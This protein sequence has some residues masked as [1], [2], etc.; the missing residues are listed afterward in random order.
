MAL[1]LPT[2]TQ[3]SPQI[4]A[5]GCKGH[6]VGGESFQGEANCDVPTSVL[7]ALHPQVNLVM[8]GSEAQPYPSAQLLVATTPAEPI[9]SQVRESD[10]FH[11]FWA[12]P[13]GICDLSSSTQDRAPAPCSGNSQA[14]P[15]DQPGRPWRITQLSSR[16]DRTAQPHRQLQ[17]HSPDVRTGGQGCSPGVVGPGEAI[18]EEEASPHEGPSDQGEDKGPGALLLLSLIAAGRGAFCG[19]ERG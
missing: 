17:S 7:W 8:R 12:L 18:G 9:E 1:T 2:V 13:Q 14:Q 11:S 6:R 3:S 4:K 10:P 15:L 5:R 16:Q 19:R